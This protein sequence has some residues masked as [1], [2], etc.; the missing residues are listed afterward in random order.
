MTPEKNKLICKIG[1]SE[2][3][4]AGA[5]SRKEYN[6]IIFWKGYYSTDIVMKRKAFMWLFGKR[7]LITE[8]E[9]KEEVYGFLKY[10]YDKF[11]E[12]LKEFGNPKFV[13]I[14]NDRSETYTT[15]KRNNTTEEE[16]EE[17][18]RKNTLMTVIS[19]CNSG[20]Y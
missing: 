8:E 11:K 5:D 14:Y 7:F 1:K 9:F 17:Q 4:I 12:D 13:I 3:Y 20:A 6:R 2:Y 16:A 18:K 15:T 10:T 19:A